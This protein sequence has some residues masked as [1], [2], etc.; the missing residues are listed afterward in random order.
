[1]VQSNSGKLY[2]LVDPKRY[3]HRF[4]GI[5]GVRCHPRFNAVDVIKPRK[6]PVIILKSAHVYFIAMAPAHSRQ[7]HFQRLSQVC[8]HAA[9][10]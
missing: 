8:F 5:A 3:G 4:C 9:S 6:V 2:K 7:L 10:G 1:M